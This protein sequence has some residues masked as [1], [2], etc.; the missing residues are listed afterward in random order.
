MC[1]SVR[2]HLCQKTAV[3]ITTTATRQRSMRGETWK[4]SQLHWLAGLLKEF[5]E[6][7]VEDTYTMF[8]SEQ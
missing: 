3:R 2:K 5:E 6:A 1:P 7:V 4:V 8:I